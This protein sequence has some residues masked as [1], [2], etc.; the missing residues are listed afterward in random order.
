MTGDLNSRSRSHRQDVNVTAAL[1]TRVPAT[2]IDGGERTH[3][4]SSRRPTSVQPASSTTICEMAGPRPAP[5]FH[6]PIRPR[7]DHKE[8]ELAHE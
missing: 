5:Q 6:P 1:A 4:L 3:L 7:A 2:R 8:K